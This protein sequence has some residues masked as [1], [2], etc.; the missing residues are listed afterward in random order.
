MTRPSRHKRRAAAAG[1]RHNRQ[2]SMA[3]DALT[4]SVVEDLLIAWMQ[5]S[6]AGRDI[7]ADMGFEQAMESAWELLNKGMIKLAMDDSGLAVRTCL[8]PE[9]PLIILER[10]AKRPGGHS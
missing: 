3:T 4:A 1:Q 7:M 2:P 5:A 8:P 9:P 10:P 6:P